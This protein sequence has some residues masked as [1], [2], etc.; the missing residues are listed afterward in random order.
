MNN[1]LV[2]YAKEFA[3]FAHGEQKRKYSGTPYWEHPQEVVNILI[4]NGIIDENVLAAAWLH[5]GLED[6]AVTE[7][8]LRERFG[9]VV[10]DIVVG[11]TDVSKPSDGNRKARKEKD[12]FH[13]SIQPIIVKNIKLA[14][15]IS[16]SRSILKWSETNLEARS[17]WKIYR[18]EKLAL[19]YV[20]QECNPQLLAL[21]K[22]YVQ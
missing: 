14:D 3:I 15:L 7:S 9:N 12:R 10:T 1:K 17:F 4:E 11:L 6:T 5:D 13:I 16:N 2:D 18:E 20:L 22:S 19:L 8:V 21:A